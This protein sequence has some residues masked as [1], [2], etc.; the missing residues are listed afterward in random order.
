MAAVGAWVRTLLVLALVGNIVDW[1][2]PG[3]SLRKYAALVV[4]LLLVAAILG[5]AV[6]LVAGVGRGHNLG[7]WLGTTAGPPLG[8]VLRRQEA[9]EV[10][11]VM[12]TLPGVAHTAVRRDGGRLTVTVAAGA[13]GRDRAA[14]AQAARQAVEEVMSWP[15]DRVTV[16]VVGSGGSSRL[17]GTG[18]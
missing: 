6:R 13:S 7:D 3:G 9:A 10:E 18:R 4:G 8:Q 14:L 1:V 12:D 2:L 15:G 17:K 16:R 11:T 5:P